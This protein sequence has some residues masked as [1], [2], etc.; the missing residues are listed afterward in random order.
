MLRL[1]PWSTRRSVLQK[2]R[3]GRSLVGPRGVVLSPRF[4]EREIRL[5]RLFIISKSIK[6]IH[7]GHFRPKFVARDE[8]SEGE[9]TSEEENDVRSGGRPRSGRASIGKEVVVL[10]G[11]T[12]RRGSV[13]CPE[14][15]RPAWRNNHLHLHDELSGAQPR[16]TAPPPAPRRARDDS[17]RRALRPPAD[18]PSWQQLKA[19]VGR[20]RRGHGVVHRAG[21]RLHVRWWALVHGLV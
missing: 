7:K 4:L 21:G 5:Q 8:R 15:R 19:S 2:D 6:T 10:R 3:R 17:H 1:P 11:A 14:T 9:G 13:I 18:A 12:T 16:R 20:R